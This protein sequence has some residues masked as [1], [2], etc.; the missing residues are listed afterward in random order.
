[1]MRTMQGTVETSSSLVFPR[2]GCHQQELDAL[3]IPGFR[4]GVGE[5]G[6]EGRGGKAPTWVN[7]GWG[8]GGWLGGVALDLTRPTPHCSVPPALSLPSS[9]RPAPPRSRVSPALPCPACHALPAPPRPCP[10]PALPRPALPQVRASVSSRRCY[11]NQDTPLLHAAAACRC[12]RGLRHMAG[13]VAKCGCTSIRTARSC[14]AAG[15]AAGQSARPV[16][17]GGAGDR[18]ECAPPLAATAERA[19]T[20]IAHAP[21]PCPALPC[22]ALPLP[23]LPLPPLPAAGNTAI[24]K[25]LMHSL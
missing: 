23:A 7:D 4:A 24:S 8:W 21:V 11:C 17:G 5:A 9:P 3:L 12:A 22:P 6:G 25:S 19:I 13:Q 2:A 20:A 16:S 10:C 14:S 1:M 15:Q 18:W